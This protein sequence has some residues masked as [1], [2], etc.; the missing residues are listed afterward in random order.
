[1]TKRIAIVGGGPGALGAAYAL[2]KTPH[3]VTVFERSGALGGLASSITVGGAPLESFYHH[4]FPTY[5]DF[6]AAAKEIGVADKIFFARAKTANYYGGTLYPF[7][8]ALDLLSFSPLPLRERLATAWWIAYLKF[9]KRRWQDFEQV[10]AATWL[11]AHLGRTAYRVIWEPLL[12]SKFGRAA[13]TI[14]MAWMWGKIYERPARFGYFAG[15]FETWFSALGKQL[16]ARGVSFRLNAEIARLA[17]QGGG[18]D[19]AGPDGTEHFDAVIVAA[20]PMTLARL[21]GDFLPRE[22]LE[23]LAGLRYV[24]VICNVLVLKKKLSRFYWTNIQDTGSPFVVIVEQTNFVPERTYGGLHPVYLSRYLDTD[25]PLYRAPKEEIERLFRRKLKEVHPHFDESWVA[26]SHVFRAPYAQ[27]IVPAGYAAMRPSY[28][29]P[30]PNLW[31]VSM[32]HVYPLDRG[33]N[34]SF[35]E[36][37]NLA[38]EL[39]ASLA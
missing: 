18:F 38:R 25:E 31:W 4:M 8:S 17:P 30:A 13:P 2:S 33:T 20:P 34:H 15:G 19:L 27:H 29:T 10:H 5:L 36:G 26:E 7:S 21:G 11:P 35:A 9:L 22:F 24:G 12:L 3:K 6:F 1:M 28:R 39:V 23:R 32:S 14:G 37:K 16:A